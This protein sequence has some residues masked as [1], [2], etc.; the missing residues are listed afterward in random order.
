MRALALIAALAVAGCATRPIQ[1]PKVVEVVVE[2][3][4]AVPEELTVPCRN[5]AKQD[6]SV[7]EAVRLANTRD[8]YLDEC[9]KR[10]QRIRN[11]AP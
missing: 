5:T 1:P 3:I 9:S 2:K 7:A 10:M 4:V 6:N 11:L 8:E